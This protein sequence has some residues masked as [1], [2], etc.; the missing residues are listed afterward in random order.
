MVIMTNLVDYREKINRININ[1]KLDKM[2]DKIDK[3]YEEEGLTDEVLDLQVEL[4]EQR[5]EHDIADENK[6]IHKKYVQ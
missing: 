5:N 2:Q 4:N 3:L 1:R 6:I